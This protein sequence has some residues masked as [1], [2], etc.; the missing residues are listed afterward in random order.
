MKLTTKEINN[1]QIVAAIDEEDNTMD[2]AIMI[3]GNPEITL[4]ISV[5]EEKATIRKWV[6]YG[7][8]EDESIYLDELYDEWLEDEEW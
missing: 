4:N 6:G 3:N 8:S 5:D 7:D 2:I 1:K